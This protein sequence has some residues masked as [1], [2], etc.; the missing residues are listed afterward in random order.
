MDLS[1][2]QLARKYNTDKCWDV[3]FGA[4]TGH[5]Y[6]P[7]YAELFKDKKVGRLL[8]IGIYHGGSL[9]MWEEFF[10]EARIV[11]LDIDPSTLFSYGRINSHLCDQRNL[12]DLTKI[13]THYTDLGGFDIIIDDGSHIPSDQAFTANFLVPYLSPGGWYI[14]EDVWQG[15]SERIQQALQYPSVVHEFKV[16]QRSDDRLIIIRSPNA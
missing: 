11:G 16:Q 3:T 13:A 12:S 14:I 5:S 4:P 2:C 1:L 10:P 8:E 15:A 9:R 6:T 7:F